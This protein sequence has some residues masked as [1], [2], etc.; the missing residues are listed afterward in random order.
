MFTRHETNAIRDVI[1]EAYAPGGAHIDKWLNVAGVGVQGCI[2]D[3]VHALSADP[4]MKFYRVTE[5]SE[6]AGY[7]GRST[8]GKQLHT[9]FIVPTLRPRKLEFFK[10]VR[11]EM[12]SVFYV[13]GYI[14][15]EPACNFYR[16]MG[17]KE[18]DT[19]TIDNHPGIV[20]QFD[21]KK[22]VEGN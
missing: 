19:V 22:V 10:Q 3:Q 6:F 14:K 21:N 20:F 7:F 2:D 15:N 5:N 9:I 16:K 4:T 17:G 8:D 13:G 1:T 12:Q 11:D 18:V